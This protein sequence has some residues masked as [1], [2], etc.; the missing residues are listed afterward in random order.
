MEL[1]ARTFF[2]AV[3]AGLET[4]RPSIGPINDGAF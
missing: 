3:S 4:V 2:V 1:S